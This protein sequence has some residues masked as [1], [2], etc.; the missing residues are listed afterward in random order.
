MVNSEAS[1]LHSEPVVIKRLTYKFPT[2]TTIVQ[3][4][5]YAYDLTDDLRHMGDDINSFKSRIK[6]TN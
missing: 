3:C 4:G 1:H 6:D 2:F 5:D